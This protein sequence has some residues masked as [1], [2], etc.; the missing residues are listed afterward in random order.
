MGNGHTISPTKHSTNAYHENHKISKQY[1]INTTTKFTVFTL[2]K[3]T[4]VL[5]KASTVVM[6]H[7]TYPQP[8]HHHHPHHLQ[9]P[10][11]PLSN[12]PGRSLLRQARAHPR[13]AIGPF[14]S[15]A[16][17]DRLPALDGPKGLNPRGFHE[18]AAAV[19][20]QGGAHHG[21]SRRKSAGLCCVVQAVRRVLIFFF[22]RRSVALK[23]CSAGVE[24]GGRVGMWRRGDVEAWKWETWDACV[25]F[26]AWFACFSGD[27]GA[28][29]ADGC[30]GLG[31]CLFLLFLSSVH[32]STRAPDHFLWPSLRMEINLELFMS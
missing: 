6:A 15:P 14:A 27:G 28:T 20:G 26:G 31:G 17:D 32:R 29:Q 11:P 22:Y 9:P 4:A 18:E 5:S 2:F 16:G 23:V 12:S 25:R 30:A 10:P 8:P 24:L 7:Q 3:R 13:R 1:S 21:G 19:P